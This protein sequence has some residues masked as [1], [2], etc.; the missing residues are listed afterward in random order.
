M[1][2]LYFRVKSNVRTALVLLFRYHNQRSYLHSC[3]IYWESSVTVDIYISMIC[4]SNFSRRLET[5]NVFNKQFGS[6]FRTF[7]NPTYFTRRLCR[8]AD[9]YMS[10]IDNLLKYPL[11]YTFYPRRGALP[12]EIQYPALTIDKGPGVSTEVKRSNS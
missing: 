10:S 9:I 3:L 7:H 12:H 11:D 2:R 6:V 5:K 4:I 8:F 1:S